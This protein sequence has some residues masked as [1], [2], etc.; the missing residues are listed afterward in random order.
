VNVDPNSEIVYAV[1]N[2]TKL[3]LD[4]NP[5]DFGFWILDFGVVCICGSISF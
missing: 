1:H 3:G 4:H 5:T 2:L